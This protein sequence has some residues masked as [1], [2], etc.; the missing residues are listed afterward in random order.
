MIAFL[1][2]ILPYGI[3]FKLITV[4]GVCSIPTSAWASGKLAGLRR[5][6]PVFMALAGGC[7]S[8]CRR[9][10]NPRQRKARK[11]SP[12]HEGPGV[13]ARKAFGLRQHRMKAAAAQAFGNIGNTTGDRIQKTALDRAFA[14][15]GGGVT[16]A[17]GKA[18]T[19]VGKHVF[20]SLS[21]AFSA[22]PDRGTLA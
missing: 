15:V 9:P 19:F 5:P 2:F 6:V 1:S 18:L 8:G 22:V 3:A 16:Q 4:L 11:G 7:P 21:T 20:A 17:S 13:A 14:L 10:R 12:G